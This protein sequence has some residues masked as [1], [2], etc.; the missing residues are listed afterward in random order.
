MIGLSPYAAIALPSLEG[1]AHQTLSV[2][3]I[4]MSSD[5]FKKKVATIAGMAERSA[6]PVCSSSRC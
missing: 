6:T 1:F 4:T 3:V 5:L 2:T